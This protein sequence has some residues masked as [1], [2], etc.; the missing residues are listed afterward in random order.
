[1]SPKNLKRNILGMFVDADVANTSANDAS[2]FN[3]VDD[4]TYQWD[5]TGVNPQ[6]KRSG[7]F[8]F[9]FLQSPGNDHD[10]IDNDEDGLIDESQY[11]GIDDNH[12]WVSYTDLNHNGRYDFEDLNHNGILD[13]GEDVNGNRSEE[14]RVGKECIPPCRS[15]WSPDH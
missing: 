10:G 3:T 11:N 14:R 5:V 1:M 13:P 4:I 15:R 2:S 6:G 9:A 7:Y 8:G 12:N